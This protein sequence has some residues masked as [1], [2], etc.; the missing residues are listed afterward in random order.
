[1]LNYSLFVTLSLIWGSSYLLIK[2]GVRELD[3]L[4]LVS[5]R[6]SLAALFCLLA[7]YV[8]RRPLPRDPK[9][10]LNILVVGILN[11]AVPF[12]LITWG[13]KSIDSGLAGVLNGTTPLF[14]LVIA[15]FATQDDRFNTR[16][17]FG[18]LAGFA[19]VALLATR[20]IDGSTNNS[21]EGQLAVLGA[22]CS[23]AI[24]AVIIRRNLRHI[25]PMV[26]AGSALVVG[27]VVVSTITLLFV[28][29]LPVISALASDVVLAVVMLAFLNTFIANTIYYR[30]VGAWGASRATTV[31]YLISPLS[32]AVGALFG[33]EQPDG[34]LLIGAALVVGGVVVVNLRRA[35]ASAAQ[36]APVP[37]GNVD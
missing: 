18:L 35:P 14:S 32:L 27:A 6:L 22:S 37:A 34:R 4:S 9:T 29:P 5:G 28:H 3:A 7:L 15:H 13:E 8:M 21:I 23:Y 20:S 16:K 17:L 1:M 12:V 11:T 31:T 10:L 2:I 30:L 24:S 26:A 36:P 25:E 19:G 33:S